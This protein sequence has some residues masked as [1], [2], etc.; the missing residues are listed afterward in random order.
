[1]FFSDLLGAGRPHPYPVEEEHG[2]DG[3]VPT[4]SGMV[5]RL[6]RQFVVGEHSTLYK[7]TVLRSV[8]GTLLGKPHVLAGVPENV[9]VALRDRVVE[10]EDEAHVA[11]SFEGDVTKFSGV[12]TIERAE[13]D[14]SS[15]FAIGFDPP[16]QVHPLTH[17]G[18][19]LE[20]I[21]LIFR[22]PDLPGSYRIA[23]RDD[24]SAAPSGFD[25][26]IVQQP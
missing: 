17:E 12:L 26:L 23:F 4:W 2:G 20:R 16:T 7:G 18:L 10:P 14:P 19:K 21:S 5:P 11:I 25:E 3:T 13:I 6:E 9:D 8:L 1:M 24:S 15:G 22:A